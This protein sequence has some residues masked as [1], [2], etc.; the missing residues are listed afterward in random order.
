[1]LGFT[2]D[3]MGVGT[4]AATAN[5]LNSPLLLSQT[6]LGSTQ[7]TAFAITLQ[8]T[9]FTTVAA[10]TGCILP[11]TAGRPINGDDLFI[12]NQ[13]AN[14]LSVYPPV[15]FKIGLAATNAAVS[16]ASGKSAIFVCRGDGNYLA[17]VSA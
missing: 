9:E 10:S 3:L 13:G 1:M 11:S 2:L 7:G 8:A 4:S 16:V 14:A 5:A 12:S 15:G 17:V 6:A